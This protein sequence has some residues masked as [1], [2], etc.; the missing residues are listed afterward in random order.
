MATILWQQRRQEQGESN[1]GQRRAVAVGKLVMAAEN[2]I[3]FDVPP[4]RPI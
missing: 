4:I 2:S 3:P 1:C